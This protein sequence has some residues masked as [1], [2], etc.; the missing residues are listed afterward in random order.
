L[1]GVIPDF[2]SFIKKKRVELENIKLAELVKRELNELTPKE[3]LF[4]SIRKGCCAFNVAKKCEN[5]NI[6]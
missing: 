1:T 2:H 6:I 4:E 5:R 3:G